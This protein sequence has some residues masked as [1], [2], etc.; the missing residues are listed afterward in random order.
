MWVTAA[1]MRTWVVGPLFDPLQLLD[2]AQIEQQAAIHG[3]V[4]GLHEEVGA[5]GDRPHLPRPLEHDLEGLFEGARAVVA[6]RGRL[7][8]RGPRSR[9]HPAGGA[10]H[11]LEYLRVARAATQVPGEALANGLGAR[12]GLP[13]EERLPRHDDPGDA[14]PALGAA[15]FDESVLERVEHPVLRQP[16]DRLHR[17]AVGLVGQHQARVH[18]PPVHDHRAR[19]A[20]PLSAALLGP[21]EPEV[22]AHQVEQALIGAHPQP[23]RVAVEVERD[24]ERFRHQASGLAW[25]AAHNRSG[26]AGISWR[27]T[28]VACAMA[29]VT[30][31]AI[32]MI[33][34][35][36]RPFAP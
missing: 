36:P 6:R 33:G 18:R 35:S 27:R 17:R 12:V 10:G 30:A 3:P 21:G 34:V 19:A 26:V 14:D 4:L 11:R 22:V 16:L 5:A 1:P 9:G 15:F 13:V 31:G 28:P 7:R 20:L 25:S 29:A 23:A 32:P 8:R 24:V 2:Q